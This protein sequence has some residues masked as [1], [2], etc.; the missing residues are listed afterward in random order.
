[1]VNFA[2]RIQQSKSRISRYD[3]EPAPYSAESFPKSAKS[4]APIPALRYKYSLVELP[5]AFGSY[6]EGANT[7]PS[8]SPTEYVSGS[9]LA[10]GTVIEPSDHSDRH[11]LS[12]SGSTVNCRE[13]ITAE[14]T[15][16]AF[17]RFA[18]NSTPPPLNIVFLSQALSAVN[19]F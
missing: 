18:A 11:L 8:N 6:P 19:F 4:L 10:T 17:R 16:V 15:A 2:G 3:K 9:D 1:M 12:A 13:W 14:F 5:V 7:N